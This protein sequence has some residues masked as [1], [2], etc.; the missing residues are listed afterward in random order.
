MKNH[1]M[2]TCA[3]LN[4]ISIA[5]VFLAVIS[6]STAAD[7]PM[8]NWPTQASG[9][10]RNASVSGSV[11]TRRLQIAWE[12]PVPGFASSP[13]VVD[14]RIYYTE[15][16][17]R[18][19]CLDA[20][21]GAQIWQRSFLPDPHSMTPPTVVGNRVLFGRFNQFNDSQM[22]AL[23]AVDGATVWSTPILSQWESYGA[24]C[25]FGGRVYSGGGLYGG[26]YGHDLI[27]GTQLFF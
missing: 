22:I 8:G 2:I 3:Q 23:N 27:T 13:A 20:G 25:V 5:L 10:S 15:N 4:L 14:G 7:P 16:D 6:H 19:T 21:T 11:A 9:M 17:G 26:M 24:P 18:I 12:T 1:K